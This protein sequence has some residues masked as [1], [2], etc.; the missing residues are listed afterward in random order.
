MRRNHSLVLLALL[1]GGCAWFA[2]WKPE[3]TSLPF[4]PA[5][6]LTF[7][8]CDTDKVC[9]SQADAGLLA[10]WMDKLRAFQAARVRL[11]AD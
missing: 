7:T 2:R 10:A 8:R 1:L 6:K 4:P 3:P 5:P 9:L 11:Q